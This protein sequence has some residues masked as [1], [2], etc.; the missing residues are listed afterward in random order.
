MSMCCPGHFIYHLPVLG[1]HPHP[2]AASKAVMAH[3]SAE[4]HRG[5][6]SCVIWPG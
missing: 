1:A 6:D 3:T 5:E 2:Q 4:G